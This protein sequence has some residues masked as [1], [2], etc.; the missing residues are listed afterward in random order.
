MWDWWSVWP[1]PRVKLSNE[2]GDDK[3]KYWLILLWWPTLHHQWCVVFTKVSRDPGPGQ[4]YHIIDSS[5][6]WK[7]TGT[8]LV[9][10]LAWPGLPWLG[11]SAALSLLALLKSTTV[12]VWVRDIMILNK[13][14]SLESLCL[15]CLETLV[16]QVSLQ[17]SK[18]II[19][20]LPDISEME[21]DLPGQ[22]KEP[23]TER[24]EAA[25]TF[26][27]QDLLQGTVDMFTQ[28]L[29][30]HVVIYLQDQVFNTVITA[31]D[32]VEIFYTINQIFYT[33]NE[34]FYR[35]RKYIRTAG[36]EPPTTECSRRCC[37][38]SSSLWRW[39]CSPARLSWTWT[40]YHRSWETNY[41]GTVIIITGF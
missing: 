35:R 8:P 27:R 14:S 9:A 2:L 32:K 19:K 6:L 1:L 13:V 18:L 17:T 20:L 30:S 34:I 41:T 37:T 26:E 40:R 29:Q 21:D 4:H 28:W 36:Q 10:S 38:G 22:K 24:P 3:D 33:I 25:Y 11:Q 16:Y 15:T 7:L 31:L 23:G 5:L 39:S 12:T